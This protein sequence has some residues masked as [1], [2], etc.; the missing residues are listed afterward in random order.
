MDEVFGLKN[1]NVITYIDMFISQ[2]NKRF[3]TI[4]F[5]SGTCILY[6]YIILLHEFKSWKVWYITHYLIDWSITFTRPQDQFQIHHSNTK[7]QSPF[8]MIMTF[9][10]E[11]VNLR[12]EKK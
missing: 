8:Y 3:G 7:I 4:F 11:S 2:Q 12:G 10:T 9:E 6:N 1:W 5:K